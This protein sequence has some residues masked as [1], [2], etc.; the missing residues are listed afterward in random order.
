MDVLFLASA[1]QPDLCPH[2]RTASITAISTKWW[3]AD[4]LY[5]QSFCSPFPPLLGWKSTHRAPTR[6]SN[7][8]S[9]LSKTSS[10]RWEKP[11]VLCTLA[12]TLVLCPAPASTFIA[13]QAAHTRPLCRHLAGN[14]SVNSKCCMNYVS[15]YVHYV[16]ISPSALLMI[17]R[18][19]VLRAGW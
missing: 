17:H 7:V 8:S 19:T 18:Y 6:P 4:T 5:R 12:C 9:C 16:H 13:T 11:F 14:D 10:L 1:L 2:L 15:L 3:V